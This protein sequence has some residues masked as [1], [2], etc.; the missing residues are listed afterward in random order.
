MLKIRPFQTGWSATSAG[1]TKTGLYKV[2]VILPNG[3]EFKNLMVTD[4]NLDAVPYDMLIGMDIIG[5]GD[6]AISHDNESLIVSYQFPSS[7]S[8]D[9]ANE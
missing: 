6:F 3:I 1:K 5:S 2:T 7:H 8:I 4:A 9:F